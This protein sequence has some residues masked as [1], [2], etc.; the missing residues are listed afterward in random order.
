MLLVRIEANGIAH[1]TDHRAPRLDKE[2]IPMDDFYSILRF[3]YRKFSF[4][5]R[6]PLSNCMG[7]S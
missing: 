2:K 6:K 5:G 3:L 7:L 4:D 1:F